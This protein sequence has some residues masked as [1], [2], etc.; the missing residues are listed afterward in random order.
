EGPLNPCVR[1]I[2]PA[3]TTHVQANLP[4]L[5][6]ELGTWRGTPWIHAILVFGGKLTAFRIDMENGQA[7]ALEDG[8]D[9]VHL[10]S[11]T[12]ASGCLYGLASS[13]RVWRW[14]PSG[15]VEPVLT[16]NGTENLAQAFVTDG[17]TYAAL[18]RGQPDCWIQLGDLPPEERSHA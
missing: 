9:I 13:G 15:A 1:I 12:D 4:G 14:Q 8:S 3:G 17:C 5:C 11:P 7:H 18:C 10:S 2:D 6:W 16:L